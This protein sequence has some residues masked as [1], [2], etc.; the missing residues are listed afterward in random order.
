MW[1]ICVGFITELSPIC[2]VDAT[3]FT[4][5]CF[6]IELRQFPV[7]QKFIWSVFFGKCVS[8]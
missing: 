8:S 1:D 6:F 4:L 2:I 7:R 5:R 3:E